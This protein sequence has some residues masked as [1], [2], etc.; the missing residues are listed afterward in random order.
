VQVEAAAVDNLRLNRERLGEQ[1]HKYRAQSRRRVIEFSATNKH[2]SNL[3][4]I[5]Y[6][7][8][9]LHLIG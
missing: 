5:H 6:S 3:E 4:I 9:S 1:A 8:L 7:S 2:S